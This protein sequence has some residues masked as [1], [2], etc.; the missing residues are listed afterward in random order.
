M[1]LTE[2]RNTGFQKILNAL[3]RNGSP[4]P[5]FET[6]PERLS[7]CTTLLIHPYFFRQTESKNGTVNDT[8]NDTLKLSK[9]EQAVLSY[10]K[11][12]NHATIDEIMSATGKSKS[13]INRT[14]RSLKEKDLLTRTGSDKTGFWNVI[15]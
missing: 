9:T 12:N 5:I 8:V 14:I 11:N 7:F 10:I 3:E 1:H 13:T 6:D 4:N 15:E 2:G